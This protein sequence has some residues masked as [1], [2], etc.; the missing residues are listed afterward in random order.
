MSYPVV[1]NNLSYGPKPL[2]NQQLPSSIQFTDLLQ[3]PPPTIQL[4]NAV[5]YPPIQKE[6]DIR[7]NDQ[8]PG[9]KTVFVGYLPERISED[10]IREIF[11]RCGEI[12]K[13][14]MNQ[15][16][17]FCYVS[18][19][20]LLSVDKAIEFAGSVIKIEKKDDPAYCRKFHVYCTENKDDKYDYDRSLRKRK[21]EERENIQENVS[22]EIPYS[23]KEFI[24]L[25]ENIGNEENI[26]KTFKTL[27]A[28]LEKGP[29]ENDCI[30]NYFTLLESFSSYMIH[31]FS[32]ENFSEEKLIRMKNNAKAN[33]LIANA[34]DDCLNTA[35]LPNVLQLF[36]ESQKETMSIWERHCDK[37][38]A[39]ARY[40]NLLAE[41]SENEI[42]ESNRY[43][44]IVSDADEEDGII[45]DIDGEQNNEQVI[46][47]MEESTE[48]PESISSFEN[49]N[50]NLP[51][52]VQNQIQMLHLELKRVKKV[53]EKLNIDNLML[54]GEIDAM[55]N[56]MKWRE[57]H[58]ISTSPIL[59]SK[60]H[61]R[62]LILI[63][64]LLSVHPNGANVHYITSYVKK[65]EPSLEL[66]EIEMTMRKYPD[67][68]KE[69]T[70]G[71]GS[72]VTKNWGLNVFTH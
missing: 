10:I 50:Q 20:D 60:R 64:M 22:L 40:F 14:K 48:L 31:L 63:A 57:L 3:F 53:N 47:K 58:T 21:R 59:S 25:T 56:A 1:H 35:S 36:T 61:I 45:S 39:Q 42:I 46:V 24:S 52:D 12:R 2:P 26:L 44:M 65:T 30:N 41:E 54:R 49:E 5:L 38:K 15:K 27:Q 67:I 32:T 51:V 23:G 72:S 34:Y 28:L 68:F 66:E 8:L 13:I 43:Q 62:L 11:E 18:F 9:C 70:S 16:K 37:Y 4:T 69:N 55:R 71:V 6:K 17:N 19:K 29:Y 7:K 33:Q